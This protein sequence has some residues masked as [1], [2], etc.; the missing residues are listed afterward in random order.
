MPMA[1]PTTVL[2][3]RP[4][5][6]VS[7]CFYE[8]SFVKPLIAASMG[9]DIMGPARRHVGCVAWGDSLQRCILI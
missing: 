8:D 5:K 2:I 7:D 1:Q 3:S 6:V 9:W 4:R